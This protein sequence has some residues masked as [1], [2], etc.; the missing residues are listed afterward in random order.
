M[1]IIYCA[2]EVYFSKLGIFTVYSKAAT[3]GTLICVPVA[4]AAKAGGTHLKKVLPML[5]YD[6]R[7]SYS[8]VTFSNKW[9][10]LF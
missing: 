7:L 2:R 10:V 3:I 1:N 6:E 9:L 8:M 4:T 5:C